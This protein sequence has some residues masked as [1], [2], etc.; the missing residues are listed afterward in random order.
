MKTPAFP[1]LAVVVVSVILVAEAL[2]LTGLF[3][4][5]AYASAT[6]QAN[7]SASALGLVVMA[8]LAAMWV[9]LT[10]I[11]FIR[12]KAGSR[13]PAIVWQVLQGAVGIASNQGLFARPDIGS[14]LLIPAILVVVL[15][16]FSKPVSRHLGTTDD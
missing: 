13:G 6:N 12:G 11:A 15:L 14:G 5:L 10:A 8:A 2:L 16:L 9:A 1:P 3:G 4:Y 7:S